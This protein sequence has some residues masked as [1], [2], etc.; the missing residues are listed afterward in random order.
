MQKLTKKVVDSATPQAKKEYSLWDTEIK[1]FFCQVNPSGKKVYYFSYYTLQKKRAKLKIGAHGPI[2]CDIAREIVKGWAGDVARGIDPRDHKKRQEVT[3]K[4]NTSLE[5]FMELYFERYKKEH[6]ELST[7]KKD[8]ER[9]RSRILPF[10]K[11]KNVSEITQKD[12]L[13]F[14]EELRKVPGQFNHC[15][16]LLSTAFKYAELWGYRSKGTNPCDE[17]KKYPEKKVERFLAEEEIQKI[18]KI[19]KA[20]E[21]LGS[22]SLYGLAGIRLLLY[23]GCRRGEILSLKWEDV[24]LEEKYLSRPKSKEKGKKTIPLNEP[25]V[26]AL[27]KLERKEN[28]PY[29]FVGKKPGTHLYNFYSQWRK[30][31][32]LAAAQD[33]R[34]HDLRH[35]FASLAI[36]QGLD[37]YQVAKLL[38]HKNTQ[39]TTRY[40]HIAKKDL[41]KS[42][43]V[44]GEVFQQIQANERRQN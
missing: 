14:Q 32:R 12:I 6:N 21:I 41:I 13:D 29:V 7:I 11:H 43:Q 8:A 4:E 34:I 23:T 1:G 44:V 31:R 37:L 2:T 28:N 17:V 19:L 25:S 30:V 15:F 9:L 10:F 26:E 33:V 35:T 20:E 27:K 39:T 5:K 36:K 3:L 42:A 24:F 22:L 38:G 40:A 18:E 16:T